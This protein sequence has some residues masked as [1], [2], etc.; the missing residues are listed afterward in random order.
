MCFQLIEYFSQLPKGVSTINLEIFD[1]CNFT[2]DE[3]IAWTEIRIPDV[4]LAGET[5]EDWYQLNGKLGDGKEGM[6]D[7]VLSFSPQTAA[8][9]GQMYQNPIQPVMM[10]PNVSGRALPVFITPQQQQPLQV[11]QQQIPQ[12]QQMPLQPEQPPPQLTETDLV[13]VRTYKL[14]STYT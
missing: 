11:V 10:V 2:M 5:H 9:M 6:I 12:Q 8:Q 1:E 4:V 7:I 3:L 14:F 13:Q